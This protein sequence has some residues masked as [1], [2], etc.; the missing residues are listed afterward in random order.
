MITADFFPSL[1]WVKP[2]ELMEYCSKRIDIIDKLNVYNVNESMDN[3]SAFMCAC[4]NGNTENIKAFLKFQ[5]LDYL[6]GNEDWYNALSFACEN[7]TFDNFRLI[8]ESRDWNI[9][10]TSSSGMTLLMHACFNG[11]EKI[12]DFIL[13]KD[14]TL[15]ELQ[16]DSGNIALMYAC[17]GGHLEIVQKLLERN[18]FDLEKYCNRDNETLFMA[19][20]FGGNADVAKIFFD[21]KNSCAF[22]K[23]TPLM[24]AAD[25]G[26]VEILK[27][28]LEKYPDELNKKDDD[29]DSALIYAIRKGRVEAVKY[30]LS[31]PN[32]DVNVVSE[33]DGT[34]LSISCWEDAPY[35]IAEALLNHPQIDVNK[36]RDDGATP[37]MIACQQGRFDI[38]KKLLERKDIH[39][40]NLKDND[41][42][43]VFM[44]ACGSWENDEVEFVDYL[45][46]NYKIN[47]NEQNKWGRT[48][49]T[50][51]CGS[52][53]LQIVKYLL[54]QRDIDLQ[55]C[56]NLLLPT[57]WGSN[58]S[59]KRTEIMSILLNLPN[60]H[61]DVNEGDNCHD[62]TPLMHACDNC[63]IGIIKQ[64]LQHPD[65]DVNKVEKDGD[66]PAFT[67]AC[68]NNHSSL[69]PV[70]LLL[71][72]EELNTKIVN[73]CGCVPLNSA[74][75][76]NILQYLLDNVYTID[77][78]PDKVEYAWYLVNNATQDCSKWFF[79]KYGDQFDFNA[80]DY[81]TPLQAA[82]YE[83]YQQVAE[84]MCKRK[85]I[86][87]N[88]SGK[89][90]RV[91]ILEALDGEQTSVACAKLL[92]ER[93]EINVNCLDGNWR[94][95]LMLAC[96][97]GSLDVAR[98]I[99][100]KNVLG[101]NAK[102]YRGNTALMHACRSFNLDLVRYLLELPG[103]DLNATN[104]K[105]KTALIVAAKVNNISI[106][107]ELL[108]HKEIDKN[109]KTIAGK[110][111]LDYALEKKYSLVADIL[112]A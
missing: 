106:V 100:E 34:A 3:V 35:E 44:H 60:V 25:S 51:A 48:S 31:I 1:K 88:Y 15:V 27:M 96:K 63:H 43:T 99:I 54:K 87:V 8:F 66:I 103:I 17:A 5:Q 53:N 50:L 69:E 11:Y 14:P 94:N 7:G 52:G 86:D 95:P 39:D 62:T 29:N 85:E 72:R 59:E 21:S 68:T 98:K 26:S 4:Y 49:I 58:N 19:A 38:A 97:H 12:V 67:Y 92:L 84:T 20:C 64:L 41:G 24:F 104:N 45:L 22:N 112:R 13:E 77:D 79:E 109:I 6:Q 110:T 61:F 46:K 55:N 75:D 57:C 70:K 91:A 36:S 73:S 47:I 18:S 37:L 33:S 107:K 76:K 89:E 81:K 28:I 2:T 9:R 102:D 32:I 82:C 30:L 83:G 23:K 10:Q 111:A 93:T 42:A 78:I 65:I 101:I 56:G 71:E 80:G 16:D 105:R 108:K 90:R 74:R 40:I